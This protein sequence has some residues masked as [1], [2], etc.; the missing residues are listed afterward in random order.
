MVIVQNKSGDEKK[1]S[2]TNFAMFCFIALNKSALAY[3]LQRNLAANTLQ[4]LYLF[5]SES[6][7]QEVTTF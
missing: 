4:K 3:E 2:G 1:K 6:E 7:I 5:Y